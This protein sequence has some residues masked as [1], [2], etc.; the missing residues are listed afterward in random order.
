MVSPVKGG[1][2]AAQGGTSAAGLGRLPSSSPG[3]GTWRVSVRGNE[4]P[5]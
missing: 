3:S 5:P 4:H 1:I 2:L